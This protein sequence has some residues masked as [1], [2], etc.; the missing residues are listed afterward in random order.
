MLLRDK[1]AIIRVVKRRIKESK[2][3]KYVA[4]AVVIICVL[5]TFAGCETNEYIEE[6]YTLSDEE[7]KLVDFAYANRAIWETSKTSHIRYV[8]K[9]GYHFLLV[10]NSKGDGVSMETK[11]TLNLKENKVYEAHLKEYGS[12]D[13]GLVYGMVSYDA[14]ADET[15][16]K[17]ALGRAIS[18]K[19]GVINPAA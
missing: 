16:K 14:G 6:E 18:G 13:V 11:Y 4:I 15:A 7:Q 5:M 9:N 17:E 10:G 2:M 8:N 1:F 19:S 3:K 12:G